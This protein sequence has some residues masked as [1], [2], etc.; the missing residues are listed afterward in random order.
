MPLHNE[1]I[2]ILIVENDEDWVEII[3][4]NL[5]GNFHFDVASNIDDV[6][7]LLLNNTYN[8]IIADL[9]LSDEETPVFGILKDFN[10]L[11]F[12]IKQ[13]KLHGNIRPPIIVTTIHQIHLQI[14]KLLNYYGGWVWGWHEKQKWIN[15]ISCG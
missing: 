6:K 2:R 7:A 4:E 3:R 12:T 11:I 1:P 14:P 5:P 8:L 10:N 13:V 9:V 15:W